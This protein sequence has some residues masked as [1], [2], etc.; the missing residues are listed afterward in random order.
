[1]PVHGGTIGVFGRKDTNIEPRSPRLAHLLEEEELDGLTDP[2]TYRHFGARVEAFRQQLLT[3]LDRLEARRPPDRRLRRR[4][5]GQHAAQLL[6]HRPELLDYVADK[7]PLKQ[8]LYTP[9]STCRCVEASSLTGPP[10]LHADPGL[11]HGRRDRRQQDEYRDAGG[12]FIVP[13]PE[14]RVLEHE[15]VAIRR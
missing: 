8:G 13:M 11:E 1:M 4:G 9:G 14:F 7:N 15:P 10:G 2:E 3:M 5:Q 6:R 12:R